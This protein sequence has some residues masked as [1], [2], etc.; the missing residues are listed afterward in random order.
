[1]KDDIQ[2]L[3]AMMLTLTAG[4]IAFL[5]VIAVYVAAFALPII[6]AV[7]TLKYMGVI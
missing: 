6:V 1:M 2:A 3:L 5:L 7:W 4:L